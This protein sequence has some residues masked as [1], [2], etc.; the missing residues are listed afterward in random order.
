[1][2]TILCNIVLPLRITVLN[3]YIDQHIKTV[4]DKA[5]L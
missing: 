2:R 1:M 5:E 3:T 4:I